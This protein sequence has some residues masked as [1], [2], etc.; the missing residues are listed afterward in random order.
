[1]AK[2]K[3]N[4]PRYLALLGILVLAGILIGVSFASSAKAAAPEA[5]N[6][7]G[8]ELCEPD[9]PFALTPKSGVAGLLGER[10]KQI[11]TDNSPDHI[12]S[13]GGFSG[14]KSYTYDLG[15]NPKDWFRNANA[16][17]GSAFSNLVMSTG[18]AMV[19]LADSTDRRAWSP[20][21]VMSF[22]DD[23]A[24]RAM[25][26]SNT[27]LI[28]PYLGISLAAV[29]VLMLLRAREGNISAQ[30]KSTGWIMVVLAIT[31]GLL[32]FPMITAKAGTR[33][34][35]ESVAALNGGDNPSDAVTNQVVKNV[36]YQGWLRRN[37]GDDTVAAEKYGPALLSTVRVS[38]AEMDAV[39]AK[40]KE[41]RAKARAALTKKKGDQ[42]KGIAAKIKKDHKNAYRHLT[43]EVQVGPVETI[44]EVLFVAMAC[45]LRIAISILMIACVIS[46][47]I[48]TIFWVL[49]TPALIL[50]ETK[51]F[52]GQRVGMGLISNSALTVRYVLEAAVGSWLFGL[53]LQACMAPGLNLWW[54]LLLLVLGTVVAWMTI[55]PFKKLKSILSLGRADGTSYMAKV[56]KM[57][58]ATYAPMVTGAVAAWRVN[59]HTDEKA[60]EAEEKL[61]ENRPQPQIVEA[62]IFNPGEAPDMWSHTQHFPDADRTLP[63]GGPQPLPSRPLYQRG[64]SPPP[65][66]DKKES[67]YQPYERTDDNE[68]AR[69]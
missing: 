12:W 64:D 60:E 42:F 24:I 59:K 51:R 62:K 36:Q 35:V 20:T 9:A 38:W 48:L 54:S 44:V 32:L 46:L 68:G 25:G 1:M 17:G 31:S 21:W 2:H 53:Y 10:P 55:A 11:T 8:I 39:E 65:P 5:A 41:E 30:A 50:P 40:P 19:S 56:A 57:A 6:I 61:S 67:P 14:L 49:L 69:T 37:F 3:G 15:C 22:L 4:A 16:N 33:V 63:T 45:I 26:M 47:T 18:D 13:T 58:M 43:G 28:L 29:T 27:L 66:E 7:P 34:G 23:F 52:S